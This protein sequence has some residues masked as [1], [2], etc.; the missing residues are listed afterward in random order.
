MKKPYGNN[1]RE[2]LY[3][4]IR[5]SVHKE[6]GNTEKPFHAPRIKKPYISRKKTETPLHAARISKAKHIKKGSFRGGVGG[7]Y[8][9]IN[10]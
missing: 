8:Q 5:K 2:R 6:K 4:I 10:I 7:S 1:G 9:Y 3:V